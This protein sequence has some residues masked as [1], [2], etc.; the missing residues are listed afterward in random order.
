M[1][2]VV[3]G[4]PLSEWFRYRPILNRERGEAHDKNNE[5]CYNLALVMFNSEWK[6][7]AN[8]YLQELKAISKLPAINKQVRLLSI[9]LLAQRSSIL[10]FAY[11]VAKQSPCARQPENRL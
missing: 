3:S 7:E 4:I 2:P 1:E 10:Q 8:K 9:Q 5:L 6:D 11:I